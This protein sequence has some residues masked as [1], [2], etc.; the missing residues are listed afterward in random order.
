MNVFVQGLDAFV[1]SVDYHVANGQM[2]KLPNS[3][4]EAYL[5]LADRLSIRRSGLQIDQRLKYVS[6]YCTSID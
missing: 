3:C 4:T 1:K 5:I 2:S 6:F